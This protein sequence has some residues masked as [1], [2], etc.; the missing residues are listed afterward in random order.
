MSI[1][2]AL[3]P[4]CPTPAEMWDGSTVFVDVVTTGSGT[5]TTKYQ[6]GS[7]S[8][9]ALVVGPGTEYPIGLTLDQVMELIYRAKKLRFSQNIGLTVAASAETKESGYFTG[10]DPDRVW[11]PTTVAGGSETLSWAAGNA[12]TSTDSVVVSAEEGI[13]CA[14]IKSF[15]A[16]SVAIPDGVSGRVSVRADSSWWEFVI[17]PGDI[18]EAEVAGAQQFFPK[19]MAFLYLEAYADVTTA[20]ATQS[21][22]YSDS[23]FSTSTAALRRSFALPGGGRLETTVQVSGVESSHQVYSTKSEAAE[24]TLKL[25]GGAEFSFYLPESTAT[26]D[27]ASSGDLPAEESGGTGE[28]GPTS[29]AITLIDPAKLLVEAIE[30]WPYNDAAGSPTW[31]TSTGAPVLLVGP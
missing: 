30:W 28:S 23:H 2:P 10:V 15:G 22:E 19:M 7:D 3:F 1:T 16:S 24:A 9:L 27:S 29:A 26:G 18:R 25:S 17:D 31:N 13:F 20:W 4:N 14:A 8:E 21:G 5:I 12:A 11:V 6:S